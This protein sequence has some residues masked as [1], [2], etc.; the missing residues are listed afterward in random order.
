MEMHYDQAIFAWLTLFFIP[1]Q[2]HKK[3]KTAWCLGALSVV[4]YYIIMA[5]IFPKKLHGGSI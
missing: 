3:N 1:L 2:W 5:L 4:I